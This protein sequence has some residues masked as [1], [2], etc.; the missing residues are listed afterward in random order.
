MTGCR[1]KPLTPARTAAAV[2]KAS[3]PTHDTAPNPQTTASAA[4]DSEVK[5]TLRRLIL[6]AGPLPLDPGEIEFVYLGMALE[7][8]VKHEGHA[9]KIRFEDH[10]V[11]P[12]RSLFASVPVHKPRFQLQGQS[13]QREIEPPSR[14]QVQQRD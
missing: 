1:T 9:R 7:R 3:R 4:S 2:L 11:Q 13:R 6:V 14:R 8:G 10:R 5:E 12:D